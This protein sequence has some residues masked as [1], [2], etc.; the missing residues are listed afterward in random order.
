[1]SRDLEELIPRAELDGVLAAAAA[2]A[3]AAPVEVL[4]RRIGMGSA[5]AQ[6]AGA[7]R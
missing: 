6:V 1:M 4:N 7:G 3:D 5:R 2:W